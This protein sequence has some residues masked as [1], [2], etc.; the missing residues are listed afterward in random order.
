MPERLETFVLSVT[1]V[2]VYLN[3]DTQKKDIIKENRNKCG[4][5]KWKNNTTNKEYIGSSTNLVSR[6]YSY[7]SLKHLVQQTSSLICKALLKYGHS[8][9]TLEILEY[10]EPSEVIAREQH[11]INLLEP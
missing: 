8:V 7:Y 3:A 2:A 11:Y 6:I 1:P 10:C 9:F 4:V 5:Y